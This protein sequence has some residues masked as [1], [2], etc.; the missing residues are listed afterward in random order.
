MLSK[1]ASSTIFWVFGMT[2]PGI[3]P[4][5]PGPLA[6]TLLNWNF[7]L[8]INFI[9][10]TYCNETIVRIWDLN[11]FYSYTTL[12][13]SIWALFDLSNFFW[14]IANSYLLDTSY[15]LYW[16]MYNLLTWILNADVYFKQL[17]PVDRTHFGRP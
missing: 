15:T 16:C 9:H 1:E 6:N 4:R 8:I 11:Y 12:P 14:T 2:R 7:Y 3:E 17:N 10:K 13:V 5:S